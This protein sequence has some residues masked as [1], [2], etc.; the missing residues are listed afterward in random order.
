LAVMALL[1]GGKINLRWRSYH[2]ESPLSS[3]TLGWPI[4]M[5]G[6]EGYRSVRLLLECVNQQIKDG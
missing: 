4:K 3:R 6:R 5:N 1:M 2:E